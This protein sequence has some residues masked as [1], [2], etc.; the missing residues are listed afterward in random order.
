[1][2]PMTLWSPCLTWLDS[3]YPFD[4]S[5]FYFSS[6]QEYTSLVYSPVHRPSPADIS[7]PLQHN[8]SKTKFKILPLPHLSPLKLDISVMGAFMCPICQARNSRTMQVFFQAVPFI[9]WFIY[10][11]M[12][13]ECSS[14]PRTCWG[15]VEGDN[16]WLMIFFFNFSESYQLHCRKWV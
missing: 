8:I 2:T 10:K 3:L 5:V 11:L 9:Y 4:T 7:R 14:W 6:C 12:R 15:G 1:M 16:L 13:F